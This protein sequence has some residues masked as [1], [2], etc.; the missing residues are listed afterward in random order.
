[1]SKKKR[2][3]K[4]GVFQL[5]TFTVP[6]ASVNIKENVQITTNRALTSSR[7]QVINQA[8]KFHLEGNISEAAKSY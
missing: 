6:F 3:Q 5:K 1:V 8:I 4:Q 7:E 2:N